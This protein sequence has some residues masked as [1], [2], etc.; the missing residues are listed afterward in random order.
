[1]DRLQGRLYAAFVGTDGGSL[2]GQSTLCRSKIPRCSTELVV[3]LVR[4]TLRR[5]AQRRWRTHHDTRTPTEGSAYVRAV[6]SIVLGAR[7]RPTRA[8]LALYPWALARS[9]AHAGM[10]SG[11]SQPWAELLVGIRLTSP[12]ACPTIGGRAVYFI[13]SCFPGA[14][15]VLLRRCETNNDDDNKPRAVVFYHGPTV[16]AKFPAAASQPDHPLERAPP[17]LAVAH[18]CHTCACG[19]NLMRMRRGEPRRLH[20]EGRTSI[21]TTFVHVQTKV[22]PLMPPSW[23]GNGP[24]L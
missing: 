13:F 3:V 10:I 5:P 4:Q 16:C 22:R 23:P 19:G 9:G 14:G 21:C 1:M 20:P 11:A 2:G 18:E 15:A 12:R 8:M 24:K 7:R 17:R 6:W